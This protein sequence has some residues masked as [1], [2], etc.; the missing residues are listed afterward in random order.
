MVFQVKKKCSCFPEN[1]TNTFPPPIILPPPH[2]PP[3][4]Q[5]F[6]LRWCDMM[7]YVWSL[8]MNSCMC[9]CVQSCALFTGG[10]AG[11]GNTDY[12][13][14]H[15]LS[16]LLFLALLSRKFSALTQFSKLWQAH[17]CL[18]FPCQQRSVHIRMF[19]K[20]TIFCKTFKRSKGSQTL[21]CILSTIQIIIRHKHLIILENRCI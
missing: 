15:F 3:L 5:E 7:W 17:C 14:R 19:R 6:L 18:W 20:H 1:Q 21:K 8:C 10:F 12:N 13:L 11:E 16:H 9:L 4:P 2:R